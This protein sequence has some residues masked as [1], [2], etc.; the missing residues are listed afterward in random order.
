MKQITRKEEDVLLNKKQT[1]KRLGDIS[2]STLDRHIANGLLVPAKIGGRVFFREE[3][4]DA[5]I[6]NCERKARRR[7][8]NRTKNAA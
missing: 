2:L 1:R 8:Q 6:K 4:I 7:V 3:T 5:F